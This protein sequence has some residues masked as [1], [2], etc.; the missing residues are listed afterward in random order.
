MGLYPVPLKTSTVAGEN[1]EPSHPEG[2]QER[3]PGRRSFPLGR[4][5]L[6]A[7]VRPGAPTPMVDAK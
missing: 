7:H 3:G 2:L 4:I 1:R 5:A 6:S